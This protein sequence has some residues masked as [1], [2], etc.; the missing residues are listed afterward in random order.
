MLVLSVVDHDIVARWEDYPIRVLMLVH[1]VLEVPP[2]TENV[3]HLHHLLQS[4]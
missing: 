4:I 3:L 2:V 1:V